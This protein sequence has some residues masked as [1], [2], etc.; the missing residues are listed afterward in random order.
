MK[1]PLTLIHRP[2]TLFAV[3]TC[4]SFCQVF[5]YSGTCLLT[6]GLRRG[7]LQFLTDIT[8]LGFS[9]PLKLFNSE[10]NSEERFIFRASLYMYCKKTQ[11][12]RNK[13]DIENIKSCYSTTTYAYV[14]V[15]QMKVLV[16]FY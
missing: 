1:S 10:S 2:L 7:T 14:P 16:Y 9:F 4:T 6:L 5:R 11:R 13:L 12:L 8:R 3:S 15:S